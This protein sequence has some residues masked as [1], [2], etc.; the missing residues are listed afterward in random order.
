MDVDYG[1]PDDDDEQDWVDLPEGLSDKDM[2]D[3]YAQY[4][5]KNN[6]DQKLP[7]IAHKNKVIFNF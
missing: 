6:Y 4:P 7:I 5:P 2:L 1:Q 3:V